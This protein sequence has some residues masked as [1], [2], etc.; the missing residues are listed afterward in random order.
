L[1]II[2]G[3]YKSRVLKSPSKGGVRPTTD[4]ARETLFNILGNMFDFEGITCID[5]FCGTG[6]FGLECISRGAAK[7]YFVDTDASLVKKNV[8]LLNAGQKAVI[9]KKDAAS[10]ISGEIS[11]ESIDI[12]FADPP[13]SYKN[14]E[15][16]ISGAKQNKLFFV[17][18]HSGGFKAPGEKKEFLVLEKKIGVSHFTFFDFQ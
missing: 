12:T 4:R 2:S 7:C 15:K 1:R 3:I 16:L 13:Y 9:I 10:F 8:E 14:Y 5:L 17:L 6:S 18:E 11:N